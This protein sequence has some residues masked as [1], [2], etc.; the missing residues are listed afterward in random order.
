MIKQTMTY[1]DC[2]DGIK[3]K[4]RKIWPLLHEETQ[5]T[6]KR[7]KMKLFFAGMFRKATECTF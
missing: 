3:G 1:F 5:C 4:K 7:S 6:M 2:I